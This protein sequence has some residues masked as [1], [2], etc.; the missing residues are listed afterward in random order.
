MA[1]EVNRYVG[2]NGRMFISERSAAGR[3]LGFDAMGNCSEASI[4]HETGTFE[5]KES[6]TGLGI[7]DLRFENSRKA[8][9][10]ITME[11]LTAKNLARSMQGTVNA[12]AGATITSEQINGVL[13]GKSYFL[14][15][16]NLTSFTSLTDDAGTP[17]AYTVND[18]YTVDLKSGRIDLVAGGGIADGDNLRANY[19]A[20][21][22][23]KI[24]MLTQANKNYWVR[25][26]GL[27]RAEDLAPVEI[28]LYKCR[29]N[30]PSDIGL[31]TDE[32]IQLQIEGEILY[33]QLQAN[34]TVNGRFYRIQQKQ[35]A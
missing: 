10:T 8:M 17:V 33:D 11:S 4:R 2:L 19:V 12:L 9:I 7:T 34:D 22:S 20:G 25:F 18:D 24:A 1:E 13:A 15:R 28:D 35:A 23:E 16:M 5:H 31:I 32:I 27:N 21:A 26:A 3:P 30:L 6:Q 14:N 29:F